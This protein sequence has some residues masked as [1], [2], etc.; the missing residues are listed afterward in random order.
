MLSDQDATNLLSHSVDDACSN[1]EVV[2]KTVR[3]TKNI[4]VLLIETTEEN[5]TFLISGIRI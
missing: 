1:I 5:A 4:S 3:N 2:G